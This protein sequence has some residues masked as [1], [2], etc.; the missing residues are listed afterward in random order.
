MP[1]KI[2]NHWFPEDF[3][4]NVNLAHLTCPN[5]KV[6]P[7]TRIKP[8]KLQTLNAIGAY[9]RDWSGVDFP[10]NY[11]NKTKKVLFFSPDRNPHPKKNGGRGLKQ[12]VILLNKLLAVKNNLIT[13][14]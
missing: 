10:C 1:E 4:F 5:F 3:H 9:C 11:K 14:Y 7:G 6:I 12:C 2:L 13:E 8:R